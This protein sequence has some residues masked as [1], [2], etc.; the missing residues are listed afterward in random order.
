MSDEPQAA[1]EDLYRVEGQAELVNGKIV[2]MPLHVCSVAHA[3]GEILFSLH[4]YSE[5][6]KR[7]Y[8]LGSTVA[9]IVDLPHRKAFCPDVALYIGGDML[10]MKFPEGAPIFA[11]EVRDPEDYG[12]A[13]EREIA[14]KR[15]DYFAAGTQVVWDVDVLREKVVRVYRRYDPG[16]PA[17]YHRSEIAEAEPALPGWSMPV[18]DLFPQPA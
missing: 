9:Y 14:Q 12:P 11:V 18:D 16:Q 1:V 2:R 10:S 4:S 7:G 17:I 13:A 8:A 3:V 6:G 5:R 15:A